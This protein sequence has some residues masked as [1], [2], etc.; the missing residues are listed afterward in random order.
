MTAYFK[1]GQL[2]FDSG[3]FAASSA[4]CCGTVCDTEAEP[5]LYKAVVTANF[6]PCD[7]APPQHSDCD[8][9]DPSGEYFSAGG[10]AYFKAT[11]PGAWGCGIGDHFDNN[12]RIIIN[13]TLQYIELAA[14]FDY[15][16][17]APVRIAAL[18]SVQP[19]VGVTYI[20]TPSTGTVTLGGV[21]RNRPCLIEAASVVL[22][23]L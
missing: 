4:C 3:E 14:S 16:P 9:L 17:S 13:C 18:E 2:L 20:L 21:P 10:L 5:T 23:P 6:Y 15:G 8:T 7:S 12:F 1:D 11:G 19:Q 22:T